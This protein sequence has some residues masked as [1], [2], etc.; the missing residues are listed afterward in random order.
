MANHPT[1]GPA[2]VHY[3]SQWLS[4]GTLE[5][6]EADV[7]CVAPQAAQPATDLCQTGRTWGEPPGSPTQDSAKDH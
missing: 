6:T 4:G 1:E 2:V 7:Q 5:V 3:L